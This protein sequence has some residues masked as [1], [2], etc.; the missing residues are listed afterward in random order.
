MLI[1]NLTCKVCFFL[2]RIAPIFSLVL[3]QVAP[4]NVENYLIGNLQ[5][6]ENVPIHTNNY[7]YTTCLIKLVLW[8]D[9]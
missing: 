2:F 3:A 9:F 7:L 5:A 4:N 1:T 8:F 6:N